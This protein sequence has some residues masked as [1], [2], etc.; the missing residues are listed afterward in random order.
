MA[1]AGFIPR[2]QD[3]QSLMDSADSRIAFSEIVSALSFALDLTEDAVPGHAVRSCLLGMRIGL[4]IGLNNNQLSDLYYALL[5]KDIGCSS[6][7]ARMCQILGG[8]DRR[9]KREVKTVDWTRPT[10]AGIRLAWNIALPGAS[11]PRRIRRLVWLGLTQNRHNAEMIG[12]RCERGASI[13]RKIGLSEQCAHTIHALDEHWDG[14]GYP[15]RSRGESIPLLSRILGVAQHLDVFAGDRSRQDAIATL[16]KRSGSWFDPDLVRA[17]V[18]LHRAGTLWTGCGTVEERVRVMELEPGTVRTLATEQVDTVC[19]AFADVVDAKSSYTYRHSLGVT[20]VAD[21]IARRLGQPPA[22][23]LL[24]HRAALLHDLGKLRVPNS[25]L[26]KPGKLDDSEWAVMR[27]H[28]LLSQQIL[29]R[30]PRFAAIA[31][32]AGRH[33]E[34]LDG[35]GYP[36][37]LQAASLSLED[38]VVALADIYGALAEDRPYRKALPTET[39]LAILRKEVPTKL[40]PE[41][42]AALLSFIDATQRTAPA[43]PE[44]AAEKISVLSAASI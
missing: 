11:R 7:A 36:H 35:T 14:S 39:I 23:R 28:P 27:Q 3:S 32:I 33:H 37:R 16:Q 30:I 34:K 26:D 22:T 31:R 24:I 6:N 40:D 15:D 13:V 43:L 19:E 20:E 21:E 42:F 17:A 44:P 10:A 25:I 18:S 1:A 4:A 41:C 9:A 5:L 38:R 29:Q 8:D 12:L 2:Q